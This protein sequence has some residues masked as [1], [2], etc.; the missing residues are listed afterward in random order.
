MLVRAQ[1]TEAAA[2]ERIASA[3]ARVAAA[4]QEMER[5]RC[6]RACVT[7]AQAAGW[8]HP[9]TCLMRVSMW[10]CLLANAFQGSTLLS[11]WC[12]S[13]M[14]DSLHRGTSGLL[15]GSQP[16]RGCGFDV[17]PANPRCCCPRRAES[18]G[19]TQRFNVVHLS[20]AKK[21]AALKE[22]AE[23]AELAAERLRQ[24]RHKRPYRLT[25]G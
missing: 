24:V 10:H 5:L 6:V 20:F 3:E 4:E 7:P 2:E 9:S 14:Y 23:E 11:L 21:E 18:E 1:A 8:P 17:M 16:G 13:I 25:H 15:C 12:L 19:R 22:R